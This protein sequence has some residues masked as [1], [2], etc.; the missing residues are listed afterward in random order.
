M[1]KKV[2]EVDK[3]NGKIAKKHL[4]FEKKQQKEQKI[5][6]ILKKRR[7][8]QKHIWIL[9]TVLKLNNKISKSAAK[10]CKNSIKQ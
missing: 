7:K 1:E 10:I 9:K 3:N 6:W 5:R 2:N 8:K 4:Y